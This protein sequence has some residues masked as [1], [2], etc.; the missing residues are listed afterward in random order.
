VAALKKLIIAG[1]FTLPET[2]PEGC[3][4]II[5]S[6]LVHEPHKRPSL[7][8]IGSH[9]WF[10]ENGETTGVNRHAYAHEDAHRLALAELHRLG[11]SED[12]WQSAEARGNRSSI[13]GI[14]RII[15]T[16]LQNKQLSSSQ[17]ARS[18]Q[19]ASISAG[20]GSNGG[21][22]ETSAS[23]KSPGGSPSKHHR[24]GSFASHRPSSL[25]QKVSIKSKTCVVQ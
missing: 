10:L 22:R 4:Q 6:V 20:T 8:E 11:I 14:Y 21:S 1:V 25:L 3:K 5:S 19:Y 16:K 24:K 7:E 15:L 23:N 13:V 18:Q 9:P 12:M 17:S 2:T